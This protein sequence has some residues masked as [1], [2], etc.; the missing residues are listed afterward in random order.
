MAGVGAHARQQ[1]CPH[2]LR[3]LHAKPQ[4]RLIGQQTAG[5]FAPADE[6]RLTESRVRRVVVDHHA[7]TRRIKHSLALAQQR[8]VAHIHGN[9]HVIIRAVHILRMQHGLAARQI[10]QVIRHIAVAN[11][12]SLLAQRQKSKAKRQRRTHGV[13][14]RGNMSQQRHALRLTG[15]AQ[16]ILKFPL[17]LRH[18]IDSPPSFSPD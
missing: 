13:P 7:E 16:P 14:V 17:L 4:N 3:H 5:R 1:A 2:I 9:R 12:I 8:A 10:F 15:A 6:I 18:R 11:H